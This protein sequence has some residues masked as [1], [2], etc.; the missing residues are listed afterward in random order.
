MK[1]PSQDGRP[2]QEGMLPRQ[3]GSLTGS[4]KEEGFVEGAI[5]VFREGLFGGAESKLL[6]AIMTL[7]SSQQSPPLL[8]NRA[9]LLETAS[10]CVP[11]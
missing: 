8:R 3:E 6:G 4:A 7:G 2:P 5:D 11:S 10:I 9:S 1:H